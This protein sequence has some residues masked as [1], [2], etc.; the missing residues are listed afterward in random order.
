MIGLLQAAGGGVSSVSFAVRE[1]AQPATVTITPVGSHACITFSSG[2]FRAPA[3]CRR[4]YA[5]RPS[6]SRLVGVDGVSSSVVTASS[7]VVKSTSGCSII[8][9]A[10]MINLTKT[11]FAPQIDQRVDIGTR[12]INHT[13]KD[14]AV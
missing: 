11:P 4:K 12:T 8:I 1:S 9:A 5:V 3:R 10:S 13:P 14:S 7:S 2:S 6:S